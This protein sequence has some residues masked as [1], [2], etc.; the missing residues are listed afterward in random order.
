M[1]VD[2]R[3]YGNPRI[4]VRRGPQSVHAPPIRVQVR[5][6]Y[7]A[8]ASYEPVLVLLMHPA[9]LHLLLC[10]CVISALGREVRDGTVGEWL[11]GSDQRIAPATGHSVGR[12]RR[13]DVTALARVGLV[14]T[15]WDLGN[16]SRT[17][18]PSQ[19][20]RVTRRAL[21]AVR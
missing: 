20:C 13:D 21:R 11:A 7:N 10:L 18:S 1:V 6:L 9:L 14:P 16:D 15:M 3:S 19:P 12:S 17:A 5:L 2:G 4:T 8:Q